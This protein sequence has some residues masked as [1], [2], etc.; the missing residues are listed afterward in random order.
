MHTWSLVFDAYDPDREGLR[1]ALCTL[2]NGYVGV[3]G[4][5]PES[6]ADHV[7][8]P[9]MYLAGCYNRLQTRVGGVAVEHE[10]MVNAPN[11]LPLTF[12]IDDGA[13]FDL[14][15]VDLLSFRQEL[16]MRRGLLLRRF[17]YRDNQHRTTTVTQRRFVS[18]HDVHVLG[19]ETTIQPEDWSGTLEVRAALDGRVTNS[20]VKR[21]RG[22]PNSHLRA[23]AEGWNGA[24]SIW[25]ETATST[26]RIRIAVAARIRVNGATEV[27]AREFHRRSRIAELTLAVAAEPNRPVTI[28]KVG[29]LFTSRDRAVFDSLSAA[30]GR[31]ETAGSF[32]DLLAP[33][34]LEWGRLWRRCQILVPDSSQRAVNFHLF[35]LLQTLS[36]HVIDADVGVPARGLHGEAY[37]GHVFWDEVFVF[38]FLT[39]TFPEV[40]RALLLYRWR[41]LAAARDAARSAGY[42]GA[43][44][45][46]QSGSDGRDETPRIHLNPVSGRWIP[47]H[48]HLQRHV[49]L[50]VAHNV[51]HYVKASGDLDFLSQYAAELLVEITRFWSSVA[52][53]DKARGR[54]RIIGVIG[55]DEFH[56]AYPDADRPGVDDNAYTNIMTARV[57]RITLEALALLPEQRRRELSEKLR[58]DR[59]ELDRF[60]DLTHRMRV[61]FLADGVIDQ[62]EGYGELTELDWADYRQRYGDIR[63]LDRI[64]EAEGDTVNRYQVSK[65]ADALMLLFILGEDQLRTTLA[66]LGYPVDDT[67]IARTIDHY[68]SR[69]SHGSTLSAVVHA[70]ALARH[71]AEASWVHLVE[72]LEGDIEDVQDGTTRE[73][74]HLGAMAG[75]VDLLI[76][77]YTGLN[78]A[79]GALE[80]E[81]ALPAEMNRLDLSLRY[82]G[83]W[84]IAVSCRNH[85]VKV[86]VDRAGPGPIDVVLCGCRNSLRPG[87]SWEMRSSAPDRQE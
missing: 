5:A 8:Y 86:S 68:R 39:L 56:D 46:W 77:G 65:Q 62:F 75:T 81:P 38:P 79:G 69:T 55:P 50:A 11:W 15:S 25:L 35:H 7:H 60:E 13:W 59:S 9:G 10:D 54:Y 21:Y 1:E 70:W 17:R 37:R 78:T 47:D 36:E 73:G 4:A 31:L 58:I 26:S 24:D 52:V 32:D 41:R 49:G 40:A 76:R 16:D 83:H 2:A 28:E 82:L 6:P 71:H 30:T 87:E 14:D 84:D 72:A 33:H 44:F 45:P 85:G 57:A 34:V 27:R 29:V 53:F 3:R 48:S 64:L 12:R 51:W 19:L 42:R 61:P 18:M 43:M 67:A 74:I 22:L 23:V 66:D 63:R 20:G 80:L